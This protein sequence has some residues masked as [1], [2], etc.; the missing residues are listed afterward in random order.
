MTL[1]RS[2]VGQVLTVLLALTASLVMLRAGI[3]ATAPTSPFADMAAVDRYVEQQ[4]AKHGI[5]GL[6]LAVTR[7]DEVLLVKGYGGAGEGG[8]P[9][10][11]QTQFL[12]GSVSKS[13]TAVAVMQLVEAGRVVLDE[14]VTT[15]LP[16]FTVATPGGS[17]QITV[18]SLL[19]QTSGLADAG[20]PAYT[21]AQPDTIAELV[22]SLRNAELVS[23]PGTEFHYTDV[24]YAVLAR[25]VE[26]VSGR[27]F[28]EYLR[29]DLFMPLE[30]ANTVAATTTA[31]ARRA[32]PHLAQGHIQLFGMPIERDELD[33]YLGGSGGVISTAEDL[34]HYLIAH[35]NSGNFDGLHVLSP[36]SVAVLHHP[37]PDVDSSYAMGWT[38][39][40]DSDG[41]T[42]IQ[43]S[44]VLSA[45]HADVALLPQD[46]YGIALLYSYNHA[47][48]NY[49]GI[50]NGIVALL[51]GE[52]PEGTG[53]GAATTGLIMAGLI[54]LTLALLYLALRRAPG[55]ARKRSGWP[56]WRVL[57]G[58]AWTLLPT[59]LVIGLP[60]LIQ[61]FADRLFTHHQILLSMPE[62]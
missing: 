48:A 58:I 45:Y 18:R 1:F 56:W 43:H 33:G 11:A 5:P 61:V 8:Q 28:A 42:I 52:A 37:P 29:H 25:L 50:R 3:G 32:A 47:L 10:T 17:E 6:A 35:N 46:N 51:L 41:P 44:G 55:W 24:N 40:D 20:F 30:M 27:P 49:A 16:D 15:Y 59:W 22:H 26:V 9:V 60:E 23:T 54:L 62:V 34:A 57:P 14:P 36:G 13:F 38:L 31:E 19:H 4:V 2:S 12:L 39:Y 21:L 7:D 53:P